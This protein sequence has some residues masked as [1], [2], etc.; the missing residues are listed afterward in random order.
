MECRF[1]EET[2]HL[3]NF[4]RLTRTQWALIRPCPGHNLSAK[5]PVSQLD[6]VYDLV[7]DVA[8]DVTEGIPPAAAAAAE[9][10]PLAVKEIGPL[11]AN[12]EGREVGQQRVEPPEPQLAEEL[13]SSRIE[14]FKFGAVLKDVDT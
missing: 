11:R 14:H 10:P 3:F 4:S 6:R 7:E 5:Q 12:R 8:E 13:E 2:F 9:T 1:A